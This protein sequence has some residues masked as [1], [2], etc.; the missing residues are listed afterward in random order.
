MRV[1]TPHQ[2][3]HYANT[4]ELPIPSHYFSDFL[5]RCGKVSRVAA[6]LLL[7]KGLIFHRLTVLFK[8]FKEYEK[9][10]FAK[11]LFHKWD[12]AALFCIKMDY[13]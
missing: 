7:V 11:C 1:G 5:I 12:R 2:C 10:L 6:K 8:K 13:V 4:Y 9:S 3:L